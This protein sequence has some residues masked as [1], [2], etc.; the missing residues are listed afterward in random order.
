MTV[1]FG[2]TTFST[3]APLTGGG[4]F[5]SPQ[6]YIAVASGRVSSLSAYITPG[7]A[8]SFVAALYDGAGTRLAYSAPVTPTSAGLVTFPITPVP[9]KALTA[10]QILLMGNGGGNFQIGIDQTLALNCGFIANLNSAFPQPPTT[11]QGAIPTLVQA[12]TFFADGDAEASTLQTSGVSG[13]FEMDGGEIVAAAIERCRIRSAVL[14]DYH[15]YQAKRELNLL[16]SSELVNRGPQLFA[17]DDFLMAFAPSVRDYQM[18]PGTVDIANANL[19]IMNPISVGPTLFSAVNATQIDTVAITWNG[20]PAPISVVSSPDGVKWQTLKNVYPNVQGSPSSIAANSANPT[21]IYD[22]GSGPINQFYNIVPT[23]TPTNQ[24]GPFATGT[25]LNI[26]SVSWNQTLSEVPMAPFSRDDYSYLAQQS[27]P[28]T[29]YQFW[30]NRQQPLP[31][32]KVW[33]VPSAA[34]A[35]VKCVHIYREKQLDDLTDFKQRVAVPQ[36]WL[37]CIID[38]LAYRMSKVVPEV[39]PKLGALL[40]ADFLD[41][42]NLARGAEREKAPMR[43]IPQIS[44][45][46]RT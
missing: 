4:V 19:R 5:L 6:P 26:A 29:P 36:R 23:A 7:V 17:I 15:L 40:K 12:P 41:S 18:P 44:R 24:P 45:Y 14:S 43:I 11:I 9:I 16:M 42:F 30:L 8:T 37:S 46:T 32:M 22:I 2:D 33:P 20:P 13:S 28:G 31:I 38:G 27:F 35:A 21:V 3:Y 10:Y 39:D 25:P 1:L 34:D